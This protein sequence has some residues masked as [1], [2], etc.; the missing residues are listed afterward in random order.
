MRCFSLKTKD[1]VIPSEAYCSLKKMGWIYQICYTEHR[2]TK[3]PIL[4]LDK[5]NYMIQETGEIKECN[6]IENR[7][8]NKLQVSQSL[9]RLRE[10]INTNVTDINKCKWITL[11]YAENMTDAKRLYNDFRKF[12]QR[13]RY[14]FGHIEYIIACE[15]QGRGAW[16]CHCLF[17]FDKKAPYIPNKVIEELWGHGFTK[18]TKLD[19]VDN[20]GAYLTAYLGDIDLDSCNDL[21]L[22]YFSSDIKIVEEIGGKKLKK[23]KKFVKGARLC[24]YPPK[25]N[26]YRISKGIKAPTKEYGSYHVLKEKVGLKNPTFSKSIVVNNIDNTFSNRVIYE[27]YNTKK[28]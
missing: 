10:Y 27:D 23:P 13:F 15:P 16:H 9:K 4:L 25:F 1:N 14:K 28:S 21:G 6:H 26:I 3:C 20:V 17:F 11:T 8:E 18:T 2:N 22:D 24:L 5:D 12:V 7:S 19:N